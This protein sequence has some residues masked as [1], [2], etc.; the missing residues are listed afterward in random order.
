MARQKRA[1]THQVGTENMDNASALP[2]R[3]ERQQK[4]TRNQRPRSLV[5]RRDLTRWKG[6][7]PINKQPDGTVAALP[8]HQVTVRTGTTHGK[9][10]LRTHHGTASQV[11]GQR[12]NTIRSAK[13][14][15]PK[16]RH[17]ITACVS[18]AAQTAPP[19]PV[20]MPQQP[21]DVKWKRSHGWWQA[22]PHS[23]QRPSA[24]N[25]S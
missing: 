18:A 5:Q 12:N 3:S 25:A 15:S 13:P 16:I 8:T 1:A 21:P 20:R 19:R 2:E 9:A 11:T 7:R 6:A 24:A 14:N 17:G 4:R 10:P 23:T 22:K